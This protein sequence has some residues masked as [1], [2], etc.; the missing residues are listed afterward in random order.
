MKEPKKCPRLK[1]SECKRSKGTKKEW[2]RETDY[3][4]GNIVKPFCRNIGTRT[5]ISIDRL[6]GYKFVLGTI[7]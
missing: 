3:F 2:L 6:V 4:G 5:N 1:S 7:F